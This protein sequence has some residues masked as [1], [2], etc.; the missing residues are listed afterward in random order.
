M[1]AAWEEV[2]SCSCATAATT[3]SAL[4]VWFQAIAIAARASDDGVGLDYFLG[5]FGGLHKGDCG[6]GLVPLRITKY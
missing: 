1:E 2:E 5:A 6:S 3:G 4:C